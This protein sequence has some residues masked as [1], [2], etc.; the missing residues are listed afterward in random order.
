MADDRPNILVIVSDEHDPAVTGCY[1]HPLVRTPHVDRL[2]SE[3]LVYD[4]AYCASPI[5]VPSRLSL[6]TGRYAH[7]IG[8]WDNGSILDS[9]VPTWGHLL[10]AA[11]HETV[12]CGR[13]H[14]N[15]IDRL[16]GF[17]R[18]LVED[19]PSWYSPAPGAPSRRPEARRTRVHVTT[20][21]AAEELPPGP[22]H[23][24][25]TYDAEVA[26]LARQFLQEKAESPGGRP[27]LLYCGL[28]HPHFPLVAPRAYLDLYDPRDVML[29][30]T[31]DEPLE[32]QHPVIRQLRRG[33]A[34]DV[35][36][37]ED[38]V[39]RAIA[40]YWALVTLVDHHIGAIL[41]AV[42][43]TPL[44]E[45]TVVLYTSD[46]GEMAGQ[47]GMWQKHCFYES[48]VRVPLLLRL[49]ARF[50][51]GQVA[52]PARVRENASLVDVLPTLLDL[53]AVSGAE[54]PDDLPGRS[55][56]D[57]AA[58]EQSGGAHTGRVATQ[59][60]FAEFHAEGMLDA[61]YMLKR[62]AYR[63]CH[64]VNERPQLFRPE[65]DPE[66]RSDLAGDPAFTNR[67]AN[68]RR[69]LLSIVDPEQVDAQAK[70]DQARR[71]AAAQVRG[72]G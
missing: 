37:A 3:A 45:N 29:P 52:K 48:A 71:R 14:F 7:Q 30:A 6:L 60:V 31:W 39:R 34:N 9:A 19:L 27:W 23:R 41:D 58:A 5:C 2:A 46:H 62:G 65:D 18:R 63:Y 22:Q 55:L 68:L 12:I 32:A 17:D 36:L 35:P 69:E 43:R 20:G 1:G 10:G 57:T 33:L 28:I 70:A 25:D 11:G 59:P 61:G 49:P 8:A 47:H 15:G 66:E 51:P 64:Y 21:G 72:D 13:T 54:R 44:R 38:V 50:L 67:L 53:A 56:L 4:N 16:H 26:A 24:H 40:A 42:N